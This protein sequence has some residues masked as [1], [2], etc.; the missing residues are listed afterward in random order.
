ME[1]KGTVTLETG[2]LV[3]RRF[4]LA[5][6]EAMYENW[7]SEEAV[8]E[9][10][11]WPAHGS[12]D[13]TRAVLAD[14]VK[15]YESTDFYQWAI[16][17]K[18]LGQVIGSISVTAQNPAV[19][20]CELGWCIG[21][22]WW[23]QG[24]MPEAGRA[25]LCYLFAEVGFERVAAAHAVGNPKSGRVMQK[26]GMRYEGTL[27]RAGRCNRGVI[28][29]A[30]YAIL[31]DEFPSDEREAFRPMRRSRQQ[32]SREE[33]EAI[34]KNGTT[35]VLAM[36]GDG[37]YPYAVPVNYVY[38]DG[39][40][41]FHGAKAGY[42]FDAMRRDSR[43]CFCVT[44]Q[45]EP[46][47]EKLTDLYR[48]AIV[49]GRVRLL[50]GQEMTNAAYALGMRFLPDPDRVRQEVAGDAARLACFELT[51]EHITGKEAIE[52]IRQRSQRHGSD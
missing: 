24:I 34:L 27:R 18:Q 17:L 9:Y 3:L 40:I 22:R 5:D 30:R 12:V 51:P 43:V 19:S 49:F 35:A 25:V 45:D 4:T 31:K 2:R 14:W 42:K 48:S 23:G 44:G 46:F 41:Y 28:D 10:L 1:H 16:E 29:E 7:A 20:G 38:K 26:L 13:A 6:A 15:G 37:G 47:P 36:N 50:E 33:T 8:T 52:L 11:T 39:K 32:L 21:S